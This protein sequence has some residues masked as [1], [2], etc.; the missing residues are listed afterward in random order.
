LTI[1]VISSLHMRV[2]I[3]VVGSQLTVTP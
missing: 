2:I 3:S 1:N